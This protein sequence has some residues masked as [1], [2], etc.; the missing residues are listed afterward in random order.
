MVAIALGLPRLGVCDVE[1]VF[2]VD[3]DPAGAAKLGPAVQQLAVLAVDFQPV[4]PAVA[5]EE[6][7]I[8]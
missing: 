2:G 6:A 8:A 7:A 3:I 4:I 1:V 5:N